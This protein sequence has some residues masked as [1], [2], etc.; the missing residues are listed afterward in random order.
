MANISSEAR[1]RG[2]QY[3]QGLID[4]ATPGAT[5]RDPNDAA[6]ATG[7]SEG[8]SGGESFTDPT[9]AV[10]RSMWLT[11]GLPGTSRMYATLLPLKAQ[12]EIEKA[13]YIA[14]FVQ[15]RSGALAPPSSTPAYLCG[16]SRGV[17]TVPV[18]ESAITRA[19]DAVR[20]PYVGDYRSEVRAC[21]L[22]QVP[23]DFPAGHRSPGDTTGTEDETRLKSLLAGAKA[24]D[25]IVLGGTWH[26]ADGIDCAGLPAGVTLLGADDC[27]FRLGTGWVR[28]GVEA[29][30]NYLIR[31]VPTALAPTTTITASAG[32]TYPSIDVA[33]AAGFTVGTTYCVRGIANDFYSASGGIEEE[34][35][36]VGSIAGV[37][38][39]HAWPQ[40]GFHGATRTVTRYAGVVEGLT[41]QNIVFDLYA[42]PGRYAAGALYA[43]R[44]KDV[45]VRGCSVK[46]ATFRAFNFDACRNA[47]AVGCTD[48]GAN[49]CMYAWTSCQLG[50][51]SGCHSQQEVFERRSSKG[52]RARWHWDMSNK[53][54]GVDLV[55]MR[56]S[57]VS[58]GLK[59]WGAWGCSAEVFVS[60]VD[61][62]LLLTDAPDDPIVTPHGMVFDG[63][64]NNLAQAEF[65]GGNKITCVSR[66]VYM[67]AGESFA[68]P[69][70]YMYAVGYNHDHFDIAAHFHHQNKS[71]GAFGTLDLRLGLNITDCT[72]RIDGQIIGARI[73]LCT[74]NNFA[75]V[76]GSI[77]FVATSA[78][79]TPGGYYWGSLN[80]DLPPSW[81]KLEYGGDW[82]GMFA[83]S[84]APTISVYTLRVPFA[85]IFRATLA[86]YDPGLA[87]Y[88]PVQDNG[89][90]EWRDV[91]LARGP[92]NAANFGF[93]D[94][95]LRIGRVFQMSDANP[96]VRE[97][98]LTF[99]AA[100]T[101]SLLCVDSC[102]NDTGGSERV[103]LVVEGGARCVGVGRTTGAIAARARVESNATG[104]CVAQGAFNADT[105]VSRAMC[106][107]TVAGYVQLSGG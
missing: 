36:Q 27:V 17:G 68:T 23:G 14:G 64:A 41:I 56:A 73:G 16:H 8:R 6:Y 24:G 13:D 20:A 79:G 50:G 51:A 92:N 90:L 72:G 63:G 98:A 19:L 81:D 91:L 71:R 11:H 9:I 2:T 58:A 60:D 55:D 67:G 65:A 31:I 49:N 33:S 87:A 4:G 89:E 52:G 83:A 15:A 82:S 105:L 101:R 25:T 54:R 12:Q 46:G 106:R 77:R 5:S 45:S 35:F 3:I 28:T 86:V 44:A 88:V 40:N 66:E 76:S 69:L 39:G 85:R 42:T 93:S 34:L 62:T 43:Q 53:C 103:I 48:L 10:L 26:F 95:H 99:A 102:L 84:H 29:T 61:S 21:G 78:L 32:P 74:N 37:T 7:F 38:L 75:N 97:T 96:T 18:Y 57:H 104:E 59:M 1:V 30:S 100:V 107:Q 22:Y 47:I 94:R 80:S 70:G